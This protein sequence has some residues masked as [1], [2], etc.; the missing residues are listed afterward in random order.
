MVDTFNSPRKNSKAT[1]NPPIVPSKIE[2]PLHEKAKV[3]DVEEMKKLLAYGKCE[4]N[5]VDNFGQTAL[6]VAAF[7]NR[8]AAV[9]LLLA[10]GASLSVTDKNGWTP[11]HCAAARGNLFICERLLIEGAVPDVSAN[12]GS[13]PL[14]YLMCLPC[15]DM[16]MFVLHLMMKRKCNVNA[17]NEHG[18]TPLHNAALR[19]GEGNVLFLLQNNAKVNETN[20]YQETALHMAARSG[21]KRI[22]QLL[23]NF[24]ANIDLRGPY[25]TAFDE[26]LA[27]NHM[28]IV[29]FLEGLKIAPIQAGRLMHQ[30][31][32]RQFNYR[33]FST[34]IELRKLFKQNSNQ[35]SDEN[36]VESNSSGET[37][38]TIASATP[39]KEVK[40]AGESVVGASMGIA[41]A[42]NIPPSNT[43][44]AIS[45]PK[46]NSPRVRPHTDITQS[47]PSAELILLHKRP[48]MNRRQNRRNLREVDSVNIFGFKE[49]TPDFGPGPKPKLRYR[50]VTIENPKPFEKELSEI[51]FEDILTIFEIPLP[52]QERPQGDEIV[53][54]T[55]VWW[56]ELGHNPPEHFPPLFIEDTEST[57]FHYKDNFFTK[58]KTPIEHFN[59]IGTL[60]LDF[61]PPGEPIIISC[62]EKDNELLGLSR[63]RQGDVTWKIKLNDI[64]AI[65]LIQHPRKIIKLLQ[66]QNK[67]LQSAKLQLCKD[68]K[69]INDLFEY[70]KNQKNQFNKIIC[71][72]IGVI[73]VKAGQTTEEEILSNEKGSAKFEEFLTFLG[74]KIQLKGWNGYA[75]ELD[76]QSDSTGKESIYTRWVDFE[77]MF[78]VSTYIPLLDNAK[79]TDDYYI[80][81]KRFIGNDLTCV[82]FLD[83]DH[84]GPFVPPTISGDFLHVF[85]I[86]QPV[87]DDKYRVAFAMREGV[88]QFGPPLSEPPIFKKDELFR[89]FF[90]SKLVNAERAALCAPFIRGKRRYTRLKNLQMLVER[91]WKEK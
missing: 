64:E 73:Y 26:A 63:T 4:V 19:A 24:G 90:L 25:G 44:T 12:S 5:E 50:R 53:V 29:E 13:T 61:Y 65:K 21:K 72:K 23:L 1:S 9:E 83:A 34:R 39:S 91:Y 7:E 6:H 8:L 59:I 3:G 14:H 43:T 51:D 15:S 84:K 76:T 79:G 31:I 16:L 18:M 52:P 80:S 41:L 69:L 35:S 32:S 42:N 2:W 22:V 85:A 30:R 10:K 78:H 48:T 36:D 27:N 81:R 62:R 56:V 88:P 11:L 66:Q 86:V 57:T 17:K 49:S 40:N 68:P 46:R 75:G 28:H 54:A 89:D 45:S 37:P 67:H 38:T 47:T 71:H 87:D 20:N 74:D 70:E 55:S 60:E 82:V 33:P 77:I 58:E